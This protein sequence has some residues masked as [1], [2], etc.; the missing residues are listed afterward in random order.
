MASHSILKY[1]VLCDIVS[2]KYKGFIPAVAESH[3]K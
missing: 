2:G 3:C 1:Q